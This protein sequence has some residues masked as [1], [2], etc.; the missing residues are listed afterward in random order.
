MELKEILSISGKSGLSKVIAKT[1]SNVIVESLVDKKRFPVFATDK[2]SSLEDIRVFC[3]NEEDIPLV[4]VFKKI[5]DIQKAQI[6]EGVK[7]IEGDD[8]RKLF[9]T[10]LPEFDKEKVYTSDIKK[11]LLWY[12]L[13]I[14]N[15]ILK[16]E[17]TVEE[18]TTA[19]KVAEKEEAITEKP[20][21]NREKAADDKE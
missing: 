2:M 10:F 20:L 11:I 12:N 15:E 17:E 7:D 19:E 16:F 6:I 9:E 1:K 5:Y 4:D 21:K 3:E 13:L 8:L 14:Q 18:A